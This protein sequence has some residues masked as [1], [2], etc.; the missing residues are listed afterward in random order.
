MTDVLA[1]GR[2][3]R[4]RASGAGFGGKVGVQVRT[5]AVRARSSTAR[6]QASTF[7]AAVRAVPAGVA[8]VAAS[9]APLVAAPPATAAVGTDPIT[10]VAGTGVAG[11]D[12]DTFSAA[13]AQ[14]RFPI[15]VAV[16]TA[17]DFY[18][19]DYSARRVR[20]VDASG[21]ITTVAGTGQRGDA[22][23]GGP[24]AGATFRT[25]TGVA[26][27]AGGNLYIADA[28]AGRVRKVDRSGI[29]TTVAG[30]GTLGDGG[31]GGPATQ[32]ELLFPSGLSVGP[33]GE[34]YIAGGDDRVRTVDRAGI[35]TTV[36]GTGEVTGSYTAS[37]PATQVELDP[38]DVVA[39]ARGN[40][41]IADR[42]YS[43]VRKMDPA[44]TITTVAGTGAGGYSGDGGAA[45]RAMLNGPVSVAL[46]GAG[47]LYIADF[48]N[49][50]VRKVD[51]AGIIT[52]VAGTGDQG[53]GGDN[54]PAIAARLIPWGIAANP[55]GDVY[56]ADGDVSRR[57]R[58][59]GP[60]RLFL[61]E[62]HAPAPAVEGDRV[63]YS[64]TV[65][66]LAATPSTG[67][68]LTDRL[69]A[70][71]AFVSGSS[72]ACGLAAGTALVSCDVGTVGAG[73]S[74]T[75]QVAVT[76]VRAGELR[77]T[78]DVVSAQSDPYRPTDTV[79]SRTLV[80]ARGCGRV[81]TATATLGADV[82]PCAATGLRIGADNVT[83]DL[84]GHRVFGFPGPSG[85][86]G[87]AVGIVVA[88]HTGVT[89]RN[90]T[91]SGFDAGIAV[92][93]G[94]Q[95]ALTGLTVTDNI[96]PDDVF[97]SLYGDGIFVEDSRANKV[98]GNTV[99]HNGVF[100]G[101][102]IYGPGSNDNV[103]QNNLVEDNV[104][105][106]DGGQSGQG[107][108]VNGSTASGTATAAS[109]TQISGNVVRG[110]GS[111]GISNINHVNGAILNN[112]VEGNGLYN[113][114]GNGIGVQVGAAWNPATPVSLVIQGNQIHGN[115]DDGIQIRRRVGAT[116]VLGNDAAGNAAK[117][118]AV[119]LRDFNTVCGT[120][121]WLGNSWG[122]GGFSPPCTATGG[123][124]AAASSTQ[125]APPALASVGQRVSALSAAA[126]TRDAQALEELLERGRHR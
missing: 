23:D 114:A 51:A 28:D 32:A 83:L 69:P 89:V 36:A 18:L 13:Q 74:A 49:S 84:G 61:S 11:V 102:G 80:S 106:T 56:I 55:Q 2:A 14:L 29:I 95:N 70:G 39:D 50:R 85:P 37:G 120:N 118:N 59:V 121:T 6:R 1:D 76:A 35:I 27:D 34:L 21:V 122:S 99:R 60:E 98:T 68:R 109:G 73:G 63:T 119:D 96:G 4:P 44:G 26:V 116:R 75:V 16:G 47:N 19:A 20:R 77:S 10:T 81:I 58:R 5:Y 100:D 30:D 123:H 111:G 97:S 108:I 52:T 82:G 65:R 66:N 86:A 33:A 93:G 78:A 12:G 88:G 62:S 67:V 8:L 110:N 72:P 79:V 48:A 24:A 54:G 71:V 117:G 105:P 42:A 57:V 103:V 104:G 126:A 45:T 87:A 17:G 41:F 94:G 125:V 53:F 115:G 7:C 3:Y 31:D 43:A 40:L 112:T 92:T 91:V 107:I 101:I 113:A 25:V 90:G 64:F 9:V 22:G 15:D 124:G 46:D 38:A